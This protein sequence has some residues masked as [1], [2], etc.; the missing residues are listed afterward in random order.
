[1]LDRREI[2]KL[3][4]DKGSNPDVPSQD[5]ESGFKGETALLQAASWGRLEIAK[6][7]I[8]HGANVN[9]KAAWGAV[10]LH[11]AA[12]MGNVEVAR[13]L[14]E[15]GADVNAKDYE[16]KT[17]LGWVDLYEAPRITKLL[18]DHGGRN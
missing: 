7:L 15:H 14:L 12:R 3:L 8:K 16:G 5:E 9:A 18:R 11:D 1:M 13:L 4:L 2:V 10:P 6:I 17:P